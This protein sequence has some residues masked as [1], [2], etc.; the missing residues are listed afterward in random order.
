VD[1]DDQENYLRV[2]LTTWLAQS[3]IITVLFLG[4]VIAQK[5]RDVR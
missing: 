3:I 5:S 2:L 4:T 1:K